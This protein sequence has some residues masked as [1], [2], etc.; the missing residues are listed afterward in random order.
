MLGRDGTKFEAGSMALT[1]RE[2]HLVQFRESGLQEN[3]LCDIWS[4]PHGSL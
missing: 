4:K 1:R 2:E 3:P